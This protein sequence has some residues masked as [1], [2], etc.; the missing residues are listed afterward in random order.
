[1]NSA[2][3]P[4]IDVFDIFDGSAFPTELHRWAATAIAKGS[5]VFTTNF[6]SLIEA[7]F[8]T[9][10]T[11]RVRPLH[12]V[13]EEGTSESRACANRVSNLKPSEA[14]SPFS[15]LSSCRA[16]D[17]CELYAVRDGR[18]AFLRCLFAILS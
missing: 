10:R 2:A 9:V 12:A 15:Q 11:A 16:S 13:Y 4:W 17:A 7:A 14:P 18:R 1:M 8:G 5:A 6:D 3:K